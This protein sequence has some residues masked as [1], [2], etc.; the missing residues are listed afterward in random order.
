MR[1][2]L[3]QTIPICVKSNTVLMQSTGTAQ[4]LTCIML[5]SQSL[6]FEYGRMHLFIHFT[7]CTLISLG[8]GKIFTNYRMS[9]D[10]H[11]DGYWYCKL[12]L[13]RNVLIQNFLCCT[14][15]WQIIC[16]WWNTCYE[17]GLLTMGNCILSEIQSQTDT[18]KWCM[19]FESLAQPRYNNVCQW[20]PLAWCCVN[21]FTWITFAATSAVIGRYWLLL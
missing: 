5:V 7:C 11:G 13:V 10:E 1:S 2:M 18:F 14:T 15:E 21:N 6:P 12:T 16:F 9:F 3:S 8:K 4:W 20:F 19:I 17:V